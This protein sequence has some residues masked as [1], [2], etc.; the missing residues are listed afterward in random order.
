MGE[1]ISS[2]TGMGLTSRQAAA[3]AAIT[4]HVALHGVM[5]SRRTLAKALG[6]NPNNAARLARALVER[7]ELNA[8]SQGGALSGFGSTGVAVFVPPHL[9]ALLAAFCVEN[10]ERLTS[11]VADAIALHLD[12]L[13]GE[14]DEA[15]VSGDGAE[16]Q[17]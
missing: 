14:T 17:P 7:G 9:A 4:E 15:T 11:V 6:C 10:G 1:V 8:V 13:G 3:L 2:H 16:V 5:P 12:E